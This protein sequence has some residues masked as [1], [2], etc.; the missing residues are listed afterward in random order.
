MVSNDTRFEKK[1]L[2]HLLKNVGNDFEKSEISLALARNLFENEK[3]HMSNAE[4]IKPSVQQVLRNDW[5]KIFE[6]VL[7][8]KSEVWSEY[9]EKKSYSRPLSSFSL[10]AKILSNLTSSSEMSRWNFIRGGLKNDSG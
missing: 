6:Y 2:Q 5:I 7:L 9:F 4:V 1:N 3:Y 10:S 8:L